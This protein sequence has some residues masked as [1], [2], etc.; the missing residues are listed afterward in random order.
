MTFWSSNLAQKCQKCKKSDK[1]DLQNDIS[2]EIFKI[3]IQSYTFLKLG[4]TKSIS[5]STGEMSINYGR[6]VGKNNIGSKK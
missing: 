6:T 3:M 4:D 5:C 2:H 1:F